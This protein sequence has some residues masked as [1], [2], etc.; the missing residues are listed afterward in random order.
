MLI[1][2]TVFWFFLFGF[3]STSCAA[4]LSVCYLFSFSIPNPESPALLLTSALSSRFSV[5][6]SLLFFAHGFSFG[7]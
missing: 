6:Q 4:V 7:C 2:S 1:A 3:V 5:S